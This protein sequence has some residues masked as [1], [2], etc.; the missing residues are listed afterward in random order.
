MLGTSFALVH[1]L[2]AL[3]DDT[4]RLPRG[5]RVMQTGGFKGKSR[6]VAAASSVRDLARAFASPSAQSSASTG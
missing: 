5:S 3:G 6:E 1:L 4:F 2:D